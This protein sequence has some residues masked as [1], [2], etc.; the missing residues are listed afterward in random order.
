LT[1]PAPAHAAALVAARQ[2]EDAAPAASS[3]LTGVKLP[4]GAVRVADKNATRAGLGQLKRIADAGKMTINKTEHLAWG[5]DGHDADRAESVKK[6]L[7]EILEAAGYQ[8]KS[9]GQKK[10][11]GGGT[12]TFFFAIHEKKSQAVLGIW[13]EGETFLVL[14]WGEVSKSGA[15]KPA[16]KSTRTRTTSRPAAA[17]RLNPAVATTPDHRTHRPRT[18]RTNR[19]EP[20]L[21]FSAR[22]RRCR[23][24]AVGRPRARPARRRRPARAG[25]RSGCRHARGGPDLAACFRSGP[26]RRCVSPERCGRVG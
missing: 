12:M 21:S 5:G 11:E 19:H 16:D 20:P 14:N 26:A 17:A 7:A 8:Y 13:M 24:A 23:P 9:A 2:D 25:R 4:A 22:Y 10:V 15:A 3:R 6:R 1:R 18:R